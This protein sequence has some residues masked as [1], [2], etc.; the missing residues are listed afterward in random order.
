MES[1][2]YKSQLNHSV[3][4]LEQVAVPSGCTSLRGYSLCPLKHHHLMV[5]SWITLGVL[6]DQS[7]HWLFWARVVTD[8]QEQER[9]SK[10]ST[11]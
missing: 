11:K 2:S 9:E 3:L 10:T 1:N 6:C 7:P 8:Y 4:L 5:I